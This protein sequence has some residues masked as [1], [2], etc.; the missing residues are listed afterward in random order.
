MRQLGLQRGED[1]SLLNLRGWATASRFSSRRSK[2]FG[3]CAQIG[4][5]NTC[6][7]N[8]TTT[9]SM[10]ISSYP[11]AFRI[12]RK[13]CSNWSRRIQPSFDFAGQLP[14]HFLGDIDERKD[15]C[16]SFDACSKINPNR[17]TCFGLKSANDDLIFGEAQ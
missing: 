14:S 13:A 1:I 15:C 17:R 7:R 10:L 11:R 3:I 9:A 5:L 8:V 6:I 2:I 4:F 12:F 16:V